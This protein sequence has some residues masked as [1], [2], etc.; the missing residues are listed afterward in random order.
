MKI[1][2]AV[3]IVIFL[4]VWINSPFKVLP[5]PGE[6]LRS[7]GILW[8]EQGLADDLLA[9]LLLNI[10]AILITTLVSLGL[11]YLTVMPF[12][13]PLASA[14]SKGRFLSLIGFT[15]FFTILVGGGQPLKLSLLVFGMTVF[16]VTS[17]AS[18]VADIPKDKFDHAR[19]L[20]MSE[21]RV[22]WEVV[23]LGTADQAFE[24]MRQNAAIG[25]MMLTMVEGIARSEG[26]IA[27]AL[28]NQQKHF[29]LPAM[30]AIQIVILF[31]GLFQDYL[32]GVLRKLCCP[33]ADLAL[34]RK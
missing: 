24:V 2:V 5:Q 13:R 23:V 27:A 6:V 32:I 21:W 30:F 4:A 15:L 28:L 34:E 22:V 18:I 8:R 26:G 20:G 14:I 3:Q 25:W 19:T 17:M 11:S 12:F 29:V 33:Y 9:S 10:K 31:I 1:I 16:F 7:L